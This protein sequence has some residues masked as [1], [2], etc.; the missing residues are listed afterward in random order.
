MSLKGVKEVKEVKEVIP[1]TLTL[2][3]QGRGNVKQ[4]YVCPRHPEDVA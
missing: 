4:Y 3:R 1:L 2:S